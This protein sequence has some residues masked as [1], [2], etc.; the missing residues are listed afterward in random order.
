MPPTSQ[1]TDRRIGCFILAETEVRGAVTYVQKLAF[2]LWP[3]FLAHQGKTAYLNASH[4][5]HVITDAIRL[6]GEGRKF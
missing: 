4:E 6:W 2:Q 3:P 5:G 1:W